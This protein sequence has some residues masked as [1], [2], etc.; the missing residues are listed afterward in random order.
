MKF[1]LSDGPYD[2]KVIRLISNDEAGIFICKL[3]K[4][5]LDALMPCPSSCSIVKFKPLLCSQ[6]KIKPAP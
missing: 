5:Y 2:V 4:H 6:K 1:N 3:C